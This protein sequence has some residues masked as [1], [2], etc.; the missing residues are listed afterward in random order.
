M[1]PK[2]HSHRQVLAYL[3]GQ[4]H[5]YVYEAQDLM[6]GGRSFDSLQ[7]AFEALL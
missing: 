4:L 7:Y 5:A 2:F 3:C 1:F 6:K